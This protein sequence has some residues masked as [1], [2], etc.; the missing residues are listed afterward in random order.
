MTV[1][2][3]LV[4]LTSG[5]ELVTKVEGYNAKSDLYTMADPLMI[6]ERYDDHTGSKYWGLAKYVQYAKTNKIHVAG[7]TIVFISDLIPE[8]EDYYL[9][10]LYVMDLQKKLYSDKDSIQAAMD[11]IDGMIESLER[12]DAEG[13]MISEDGI[14]DAFNDDNILNFKGTPKANSSF[15]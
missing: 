11:Y 1:Q 3:K 8:I 6:F 4:K 15:H 10:Q 14:E 2:I 12:A 7:G 13:L 9:K 5:E